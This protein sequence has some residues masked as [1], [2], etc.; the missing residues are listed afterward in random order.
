M[1]EVV[2]TYEKRFADWFVTVEAS[3]KGR[4]YGTAPLERLP[5]KWQEIRESA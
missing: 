5:Q 4:E 1:P 3:F 2:E